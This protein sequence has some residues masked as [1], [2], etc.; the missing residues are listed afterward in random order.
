MLKRLVDEGEYFKLTFISADIHRGIEFVLQE[1]VAL[2]DMGL[3]VTTRSKKNK[4][5]GKEASKHPKTRRNMQKM[6]Y[7]FNYEAEK[8]PQYLENF[9]PNDQAVEIRL[10][11]LSE[12]VIVIHRGQT[13]Y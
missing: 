3:L 5:K 2:D 1:S 7:A 6:R 4:T 11:G 9:Q 12:M 13:K 8:K 10:I